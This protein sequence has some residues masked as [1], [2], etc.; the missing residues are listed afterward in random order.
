MSKYVYGIVIGILALLIFFASVSVIG[1]GQ[2]GV[3]TLFGNV[4]QETL[5]PGFHLLNPLAAVH[6]MNLRI[7]TTQGDS[8]AASSDLQT[9]HTQITLNYSL[10]GQDAKNIYVKIGNNPDYFESSI[11][12]PA[13]SE[14]FK[15][16]VADFSAE[17]LINK[18]A[19]VSER[20]NKLLQAKLSEYG[21]IVQSVAI[22]N[23]VFSQVFNEAIEAKVT[24]QQRVLTEQNNLARIKVEA[25]Q[26]VVQAQAEANALQIQKQAITPELLQLRQTEN[27]NLAIQKWD[28]HLPQY[29]GNNIPFIMGIK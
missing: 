5:D 7:L 13:M 24:A 27:Q 20:I 28:G 12:N 17:D 22:T 10:N 6:A 1:A 19:A 11:I 14:T 26:K 4:R 21:I 16:V 9:V 2:V 29:T 3:V 18:R 25:Q 8:E 15:A 23:F